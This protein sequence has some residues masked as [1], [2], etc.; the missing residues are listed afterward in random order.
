MRRS[1]TTGFIGFRFSALGSR[2]R[3]QLSGFRV[4]GVGGR[5]GGGRA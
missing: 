2:L 3:F 5:G 1:A 4:W